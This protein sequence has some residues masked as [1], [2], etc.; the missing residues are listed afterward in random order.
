M[1]ISEIAK[2]G[3]DIANSKISVAVDAIILTEA[4]ELLTISSASN[5]PL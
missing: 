5:L 4:I 1:S 2:V 3:L